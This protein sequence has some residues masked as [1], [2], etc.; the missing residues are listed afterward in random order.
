M[1][2]NEIPIEHKKRIDT[3]INYI[4]KNLHNDVSL[5]KLAQIANYSPF[6]F[7]KIFKQF[8]GETPK[9]LVIRLKL[10][11]AAHLL[12]IYRHKS[13]TEIAFDSGFSSPAVFARGF[14]TY[15]KITPEEMRLL[16]P[17][18][19]I[20]LRKESFHL[21]EMIKN[22]REGTER[23]VSDFE[24]IRL[25]PLHGVC[26]NSDLEDE[27][28]IEQSFK[29]IL[30]YVKANDLFDPAS[31]KI[32]GLIYPHQD[33]YSAFVSIAD[34]SKIPTKMDVMHIKE[35][36]Y[37]SFKMKGTMKDLFAKLSIL[38]EHWLPENGYKFADIFGFETFS[39]NPIGKKYAMLEKEIFIRIIPE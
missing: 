12:I 10:E 4:L 5:S 15:F 3:V 8:L 30:K 2:K 39:Q 37:V 1:F 18:E 38:N 35:G 28:K 9:Q 17:K 19:Q 20:K 7:Q 32:A 16:D 21:K 29:D 11:T 22:K 6:H 23:N 36:K 24:I 13:I 25:P 33:R 27:S 31:S 34:I 26:V 14:K